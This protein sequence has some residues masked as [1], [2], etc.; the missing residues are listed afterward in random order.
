VPGYCTLFQKKCKHDSSESPS[1]F[2]FGADKCHLSLGKLLVA[3]TLMTWLKRALLLPLFFCAAASAQDFQFL[4]EVDAYAKL[5]SDIRFQFQAKETQEAGD[6]T[7]AEIGPRFDFFLK[8][9]IRLRKITI[10]DLDDA[11]SRPL[12]LSA[13]FRYVPSPDKPHLERMEV[14]AT[15]HF[16]LFAGILLTDRNRADLDWQKDQ[17]TLALS[18]SFGTGTLHPHRFLS[19]YSLYQCGSF[20]REPTPK[21]EHHSPI[22]GLPLSH[23]QALSVRFLLRT[24]EHYQ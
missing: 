18:Q 4:P 9:L 1:N 13:G 14:V 11:K 12:V 21:V 5:S 23:R 20:L 16:P 17:F 2:F 7:L 3:L 10:F 24:P 15:P 6:P 8:P 22:R 19:P